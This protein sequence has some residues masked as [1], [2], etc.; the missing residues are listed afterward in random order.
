MARY[1][2]ATPRSR[3]LGTRSFATTTAWHSGLTIRH[4][5]IGQV[6][7][8]YNIDGG[9]GPL[10]GNFTPGGWR[11]FGEFDDRRFTAQGLSIADPSGTGIAAKLRGNFGNSCGC[12]ADALSA[13][14]GD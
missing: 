13:I 12:G 6:R 1:S 14:I 3:D 9:G 2:T 7:W 5:I 4:G 8:D 10:P 11:H